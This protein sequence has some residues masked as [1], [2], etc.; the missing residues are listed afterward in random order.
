MRIQVRKDASKLRRFEI[1]NNSDSDRNLIHFTDNGHQN[2]I[3]KHINIGDLF[4]CFLLKTFKYLVLLITGNGLLWGFNLYD[5][6][7]IK[8]F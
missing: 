4:T 5:R 3:K 1:I 6:E 2:L 8:S 7:K